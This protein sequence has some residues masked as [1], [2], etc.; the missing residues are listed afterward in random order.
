MNGAA[1]LDGIA[2]V[3]LAG[4]FPGAGDVD[5][6][7]DNLERGVE[8]IAFFRPE[9]LLASGVDPALVAD[10]HYVPAAAILDDVEGFD[11]AFFGIGPREAEVMDPQHR[12]VLET[13]WTALERAA[14]E[15]RTF[16]GRV[17]MFAGASL[18]QYLLENL[19]SQPERLARV[20]PYQAAIG[21][22]KDFLATRVSYRLG[23]TGPSLSVQ[24]ACST[25]LVAVAM[26][27][28]SL[29]NGE[30]DVA[31]AGGVTVRVP[32][33]A[34]YLYQP[35]GILS[36]DGHCRP[37]DAE[38]RGT[39]PGSGVGLVV[40]R[41]IED[42]LADGHHVHAVIRGWALNN[43]G[44]RKVGYTAPSVEGQSEVIAEALA[45]SGLEPE[46]ID[47]V[48]AHGTGTRLGDPIEL[49]AL[50]QV[51]RRGGARHRPCLVGSLKGN[52]GHLDAAAGVTG[53]VKT[54]L[55]LE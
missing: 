53:L 10:P 52:L 38:A 47:Y 49:A 41:R 1:R 36:P 26:A 34:G 45:L 32:Q 42:A 8:S 14:I 28:Q 31:L 51:F 5:Q 37:F 21:N 30:S 23:L 48:E 6:L 9:E 39:V 3:G 17:A 11:A 20:G 2:V 22:D 15:P 13:A 43:D 54:V 33:R 7:W 12:L 4:R 40:L 50:A 44:A 24:T 55:A 25:S 27:C 19:L 35:E 16:A 46:E 29:A 18:N